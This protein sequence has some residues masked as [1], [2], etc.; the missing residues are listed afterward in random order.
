[1]P[2]IFKE[3]CT[4]SF[5]E[6]FTKVCKYHVEKE[7]DKVKNYTSQEKLNL[8]RINKKY[9]EEREIFL[10]QTKD[11]FD[12]FN[13]K[14]HDCQDLRERNNL[15]RE[16]DKKQR[17]YELLESELSIEI[18]YQLVSKNQSLTAEDYS[19][20]FPILKNIPQEV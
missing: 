14:F 17:E 2:L 3:F 20:L 6:S 13:A 7:T 16:F 19:N 9:R 15:Q 4:Q 18:E 8:A 5:D 10:K 11:I 12:E 1:M